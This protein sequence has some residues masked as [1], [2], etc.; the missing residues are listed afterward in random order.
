MKDIMEETLIIWAVANLVI[1]IQSTQIISLRKRWNKIKLKNKCFLCGRRKLCLD[2][3]KCRFH[4]KCP[5][6]YY[7]LV[8]EK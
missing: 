8:A 5:A 3:I 6:K 2:H 4:K 7:K 1:K